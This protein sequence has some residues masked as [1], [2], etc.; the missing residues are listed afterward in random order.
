[1]LT[2]G[3]YLGSITTGIDRFVLTYSLCPLLTRTVPRLL[4][5]KKTHDQHFERGQPN[6]HALRFCCFF[7]PFFFRDRLRAGCTWCTKIPISCRLNFC[8]IHRE[9]QT[10]SAFN[11]LTNLAMVQSGSRINP[12]LSASF[13]VQRSPSCTAGQ[14]REH[15]LNSDLKFS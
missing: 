13:T 15:S 14:G 9:L 2:A 10:V 6:C 11:C 1:M 4:R 5:E 8:S 12:R 7:F 3:R